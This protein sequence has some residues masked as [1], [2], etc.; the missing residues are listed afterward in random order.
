MK[1]TSD[2]NNDDDEDCE[3]DPI[4]ADKQT[5]APLD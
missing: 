1:E 4:S 5:H 2:G 3:D